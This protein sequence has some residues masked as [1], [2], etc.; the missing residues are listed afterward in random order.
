M[1]SIIPYMRHFLNY[2]IYI[3][4]NQLLLYTII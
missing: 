2:L 3:N 4:L 1:V